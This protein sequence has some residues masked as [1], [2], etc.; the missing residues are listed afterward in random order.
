MTLTAYAVLALG[1]AGCL[2]V[3]WLALQDPNRQP[4]KHRSGEQPWRSA[5]PVSL[6]GDEGLTDDIDHQ[7][8]LRSMQDPQTPDE[9]RRAHIGAERLRA[10][11][12]EQ[13][14]QQGDEYIHGMTDGGER[15]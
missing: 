14:L 7:A 11:M 13:A 9:I 8:W 6:P 3:L 4:P 2:Y 5:E 10:A 1:I 15:S 12:H